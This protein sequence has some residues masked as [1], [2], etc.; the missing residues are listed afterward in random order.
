MAKDFTTGEFRITN[1][2]IIED[3]SEMM[4]EQMYRMMQ[5]SPF[6]PPR[7][8]QSREEQL[9]MA[10]RDAGQK[11]EQQDAFIKKINSE[12]C[13]IGTVTGKTE[14][15]RGIVAVRGVTLEVNLPPG[16]EIGS[17]VRTLMSTSQPIGVLKT[18]A[19]FGSIVTIDRIDGHEVYFS[20]GQESASASVAAGMD[21]LPESGDR[22]QLDPSGMVAMKNLGRDKNRFAVNVE[23]VTWGDIGGLEEAKEALR[24]AIEYPTK[25]ADVYAGYGQRPSRGVLL[26][27]PPGCGKTMLG[28]AAANAMGDGSGFIYV[29]G[30]EVLSKWVGESEATVRSIFDRARDH[31]RK[32]GRPAIVFIDEAEALLATGGSGSGLGVAS[33]TVPSFL[34]EMDGLEDS[35]AFVMLSTNRPDSLDPAIVRD[36]RIDRRVKVGRPDAESAEQVFRLA[37]RG[38]PG[39]AGELGSVAVQLMYSDKLALYELLFE[40]GPREV[41]CLRDML[42]GA[43]ISGFV[44]RAASR[45]IR[46]DREQGVANGITADDIR[47][48]VT[49][50]FREMADVNNLGAI[51]EKIESIGRVPSN[52]RKATFHAGSE[53]AYFGPAVSFGDSGVQAAGRG[54]LN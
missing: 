20:R 48:A 40:E 13:A 29:K 45:A 9:E 4:R 52:V 1:G 43:V 12:P 37:M 17:Q 16:G 47:A 51:F 15:G 23:T 53:E 26:Y 11:L 14:D 3:P 54:A 5:T 10:L 46:R 36:G 25:Y 41:L 50:S 34:A 30:A 39:D 28:K 33:M 35:G 7:P 24:E 44:N 32:T 42:S 2:R 49:E 6:G 38:R 27:G 19:V 18:P 22:V 8:P 31:K 21:P